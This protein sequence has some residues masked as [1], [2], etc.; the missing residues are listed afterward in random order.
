VLYRDDFLQEVFDVPSEAGSRKVPARRRNS[1]MK[2]L[3]FLILIVLCFT[4]ATAA[5]HDDANNTF[6]ATLRGINETPGPIAT[7]GSGSFHATLNADGTTISY[8]VTYNNLN[9][10]VTQSHI[11][12]GLSKETGGIMI[13]LCQTAAA[14][15]PA[16]D[17]GVPSCPDTTSGTASGT[18]TAANVV[19][20]NG[21]GITPGADFAKVVQ[22]MREGAAYANVHSTRSPGGEIRGPIRAGEGDDE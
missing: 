11:H 1:N 19:G 4:V 7:Q 17:P 13:W 3:A 18:V 14:P 21:Q 16:T 6:N 2:R 12:F 9:A 20:P 5:S 15:A 22:A 10:Q 8:T